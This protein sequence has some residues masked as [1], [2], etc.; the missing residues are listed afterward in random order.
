MKT[1]VYFSFLMKAKMKTKFQEFIPKF[2]T[3]T[4]KKSDNDSQNEIKTSEEIDKRMNKEK[5]AAKRTLSLLLL[6]A[7]GCGKSK[8][9]TKKK[10]G[11][12]EEE[13]RKKKKDR[14]IRGGGRVEEQERVKKKKKPTRI[15]QCTNASANI[16]GTVFKQMQNMYDGAIAENDI[17]ITTSAVRKQVLDD[18]IDLCRSNIELQVSEKACRIEDEK[19]CEIRDRFASLF[20][21]ITE[22]VSLTMGVAQDVHRI[23]KEVI[24]FFFFFYKKKKK[25]KGTFICTRITFFLC[26][27]IY[28]YLFILNNWLNLNFGVGGP[29]IQSAMQRTFA[30]RSKAHVMDNTPYFFD[31]VLEIA[32]PRYKANFDDH[33]RATYTLCEAAQY[34]ARTYIY[35]RVRL[36]TT[37]I[38]HAAFQTIFQQQKWI[39]QVTDVG[40]QR[41]ERKSL[42]T[43]N[44]HTYIYV[45]IYIWINVFAG[46][47]AV[48]YVMSLNGYDKVL[49]ED[50]TQNCWDETFQLF[51]N[52]TAL[53]EFKQTDFIVFLNKS[54]QNIF[55]NMFFFLISLLNLFTELI[56]KVPFSAYYKECPTD[57]RH[58]PTYVIDYVEAELIQRFSQTSDRPKEKMSAMNLKTKEDIIGEEP[59]RALHVHVTC[60]TGVCFYLQCFILLLIIC[61]TILMASLAHIH[62]SIHNHFFFFFFF[63]FKFAPLVIA[64]LYLENKC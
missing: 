45:Y 64:A 38:V 42:F 31:K 1:I 60:A 18:I 50:N 24:D 7:G 46:V 2:F 36:R 44:I 34:N 55:T 49:F 43:Y 11:G 25:G 59:Q 16:L 5:K 41:N 32:S 33:V 62:K 39:I 3:I 20:G 56:Q 22:D 19:C 29:P 28:I 27:F 26:V 6:G 13:G 10:K 35:V 37:G 12:G 8:K 54:G 23:W 53:K 61:G 30:I 51:G 9:W 57:E 58:N 21:K 4:K 52:V 40:G 63:F 47:N 17:V 14:L 15:I 48:I